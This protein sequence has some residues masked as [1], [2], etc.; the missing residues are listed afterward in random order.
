MRELIHKLYQTQTLEREELIFLISERDEETERYARAGKESS[1]RS[2]RK[3]DFYQRFDRI[4]QLLQ[5]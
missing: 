5:K 2:L 4:H 3:Q 1:G